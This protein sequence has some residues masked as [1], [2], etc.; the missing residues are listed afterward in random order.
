MFGLDCGHI[1]C[2]DC[3]TE[4]L[5]TKIMDEGTSEII[6][7]PDSNC[8][9]LVDDETITKVI[10]NPKIIS[11]F[12]QLITNTFV[13]CNRL[14]TWCS[15]PDCSKALRVSHPEA[16]PVKCQCGHKFCFICS[17][18]Q[19]NPVTCKLLK[20]WVKKCEDDSETSKWLTANTKDCPKCNTPIG[21]HVLSVTMYN[22]LEIQYGVA[23]LISFIY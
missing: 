19:H 22:V 1:F 16:Q 11:R 4:Y 12:G 3:W 20:L 23:K 14:I 5:R 21:K 2:N 15:G 10:K 17:E 9:L 6:K 18:K 13:Q 8:D 7:C